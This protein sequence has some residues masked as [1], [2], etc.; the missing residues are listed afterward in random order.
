MKKILI[1]LSVFFV[2]SPLTYG[3]SISLNLDNDVIADTDRH[4]THG[5]RVQYTV[6]KAPLF[7]VDAFPNRQMASIVAVAQHMYT[8]SDTAIPDLMPNDRPYGGWLYLGLA[9]EARDD[10]QMDFIEVD[11]GITG[12]CSQSEKV[13]KLVHSWIGSQDPKGWQYQIGTTVGF[14][15]IY[16]KKYRQRFELSDTVGFD[17]ISHGGGCL[18]NI[19]TYLNYGGML[20][21]GYNIPDDFGFRRM[22]PTSRRLSDIGGYLFL[23]VDSRIVARNI[24]LDGY[25][26]H[27]VS[28]ESVVNDLG[29]GA[30]VV[31]WNWEIVYS[32][33]IRTK[34]FEMQQ[35]NNRFGTVVVVRKF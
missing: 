6:N 4:Y 25:K 29:L 19:Y 10:K 9:F 22:E 26:S 24:F 20:R 2:I 12:S 7:L 34:E 8:P 28:K 31:L 5:T 32:Y 21:F 18:G 33:N 27:S 13:Q 14:N 35:E 3:D 1:L 11:C 30:A 23:D 15:F 17:L 16:Q